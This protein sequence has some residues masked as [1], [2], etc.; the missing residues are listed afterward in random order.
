MSASGVGRAAGEPDVSCGR[1]WGRFLSPILPLSLKCGCSV[2]SRLAAVASASRA[3]VRL[4]MEIQP[5][6][7]CFDDCVLHL[8]LLVASVAGSPAG[9]RVRAFPDARSGRSLLVH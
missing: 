5:L 1:M 9:G 2:S 7:C 4:S 8:R 6:G 3:R